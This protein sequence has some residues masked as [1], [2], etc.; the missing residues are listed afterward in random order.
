MITPG[1]LEKE[2]NWQIPVSLAKF[3]IGELLGIQTLKFVPE[4]LDQLHQETFCEHVF[5]IKIYFDRQFS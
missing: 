5:G 3:E 4:L 1:C 2:I